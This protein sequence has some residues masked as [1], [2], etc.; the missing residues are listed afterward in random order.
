MDS[1]LCLLL[2]LL[3][4]GS[5]K[6]CVQSDTDWDTARACFQAIAHRDEKTLQHF[7]RFSG[8]FVL[9]TA[10]KQVGGLVPCRRAAAEQCRACIAVSTAVSYSQV[11][12]YSWVCLCVAELEG[13]KPDCGVFKVSS[14]GAQHLAKILP[15]HSEVI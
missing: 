3:S 9:P 10:L 7:W 6:R 15:T 1:L 8:G 13:S 5:L 4:F 12:S 2:T 11:C 14:L